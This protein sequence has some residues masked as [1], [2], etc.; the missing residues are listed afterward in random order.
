V[1]EALRASG[2]RGRLSAKWGAGLGL[3]RTR[4]QRDSSRQ[5]MAVIPYVENVSEAAAGIM[6]EHNVPVEMKPYTTLEC[7]MV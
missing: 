6:K 4:K 1:E 5:P 7:G 3:G 2:V